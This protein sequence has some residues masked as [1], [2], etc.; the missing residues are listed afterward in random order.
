MYK[1]IRLNNYKVTGVEG[2]LLDTIVDPPGH[3]EGDVLV[4]TMP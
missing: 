1:I 2:G 4:N 3:G